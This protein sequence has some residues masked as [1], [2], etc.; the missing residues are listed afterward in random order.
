M[1][2]KTSDQL[3]LSNIKE[4]HQSLTGKP[5]PELLTSNE[6][7][8]KG[9]TN[10]SKSYNLNPDLKTVYE[11]GNIPYNITSAPGAG[12]TESISQAQQNYMFF[13]PMTAL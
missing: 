7:K 5:H 2:L 11:Q 8:R 6:V 9:I 1:V 4:A 12:Y 13:N 10:Y 3:P